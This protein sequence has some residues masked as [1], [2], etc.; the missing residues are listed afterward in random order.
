MLDGREM[1]PEKAEFVFQGEGQEI[2]SIGAP[3]SYRSLQLIGDIL[4]E[5][6]GNQMS[7][8]LE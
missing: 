2:E 1:L 8:P 5:P 3:R 6:M 4:D 7:A